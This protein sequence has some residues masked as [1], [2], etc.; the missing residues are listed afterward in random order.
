MVNKSKYPFGIESESEWN[1]FADS[2]KC[3]NCGKYHT[4]GVPSECPLQKI[5]NNVYNK[6]G[7]DK[8]W[9][10]FSKWKKKDSIKDG[11]NETNEEM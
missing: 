3:P 6:L 5:Q 2:E 7:P 9:D 4:I 8:F 11:I 10:E 1:E